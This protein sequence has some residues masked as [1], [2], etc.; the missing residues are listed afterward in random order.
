M[1]PLTQTTI[2]LTGVGGTAPY[3]AVVVS[4]PDPPYN[5]TFI[6]AGGTVTQ[7]GPLQFTLNAAGVS[8]GTYTVHFQLIDTASNID[9][10]IINVVVVD[11][12]IFNILNTSQNYEPAAFPL[13]VSMPLLSSGG[14]TPIT[15][16][17]IQSAT[18]MPGVTQAS[19][20]GTGGSTLNFSIPV[21]GSWTIG[22]KATDALNNSV[23]KVLVI[24]V[25]ATQAVKLVDGQVEVMVDP[26]DL[27]TGTH[28]FTLTASD[29]NSTTVNQQFSYQ[30]QPTVSSIRIEE[31]FFDHYWDYNDT[32]SI[33]FPVVG[34]F[35]G[36]TLAPQQPVVLPNGLTVSVDNVNQIVEVAGPP[37]N[38]PALSS[39]FR[40]SQFRIP[41]VLQQGSVNVGQVSR[42]YTFV[43]H[44]DQAV[45]GD[46]GIVNTYTRPYVVG[47]F[48]GL[49]P[50]KPYFNSPNIAKNTAYSVIVAPGSSLPPGLS[51][52]SNTGLIYGTLVGTGVPQST[53][54]Y[55]DST[56]TVHGTVTINWTTVSNDYLL[57]DNI[58]NIT[59]APQIG[60]PINGTNALVSSATVPLAPPTLL[61]GSLPQ[62]L[63][64]QVDI[65]GLGIDIVGTPTEAGYFDLWFNVPDT[66]G[67]HS[68]LYHRL[69]VDYVSPLSI[70]TT[71]IPTL[72]TGVPYSFLLQGTGG[73]QPYTWSSPQWPG[74][75]NPT[76]PGLT[77]SSS[78]LISGTTTAPDTTTENDTFILTDVRGASTQAVLTV[79]VND[80]LT[81]TTQ[82]IPTIVP[83]Q[84]YT[85]AM[86]AIGGTPPYTWTT[87]PTFPIAGLSGIAFD[88]STGVFSGVTS[89]T[90]FTTPLQV[91]VHDSGVHTAT[92][93]Y[94]LQTGSATGMLIV[95]SGVGPIDRGASY[96][97][98]LSLSGP[99]TTPVSW[100]VTSD[101]PNP[102][103]A[104]LV[105]Q[106]TATNN[107]QTATIS[108][109]YTGQIPPSNPLAVKVIAV[110]KNGNSAQAILLLTTTSSLKVT[111]T[112]LP[113]AI[114]GA[115]TS[116]QLTATSNGQPA[117]V[118]PFV[119]S[120]VVAGDF[121]PALPAGDL[122]TIS[123]SSSGLLLA[124][125]PP[126]AYTGQ[127]TVH[128]ADAL[129]PADTASATLQFQIQSSSLTITTATLPNATSGRPYSLTLAA[130]GG[131]T[132]Y[133]WSISPSSANNLPTGLALNP[134]TGAITGTTSLT[135]FNK[136]I[137]FRV[138][139]N[140]G[141]HVDK[142]LN[143]Q[144]IAGLTLQ[145]G[146]DYVDSTNYGYIGFVAQG[147][148]S[149]ITPRPNDSFFVVATG[150]VSTN[151]S[152]ITLSVGTSG[153]TA[154]IPS[155]GLDTGTGTCLIE[156]NG[157][158]S[159]GVI[160]DNT[161][162]LSV[163]DSGVNV[164]G[165]FK[166]RVYS[167]TAIRLAATNPI[168]TQLIPGQ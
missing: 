18:T 120:N 134:S 30:V 51:L 132:P 114:I 107:G 80:T 108:G 67:H 68:Y 47:D 98:T 1:P 166:W 109:V 165:S 104:G 56:G 39:T 151:P 21:V 64:L 38:P 57:I 154:S 49:N 130:T 22:V 52:D 3:H 32:T 8:P 103:P 31:A 25:P 158:F 26:N 145:A 94:T 48:V 88:G 75:L 111:T 115:S 35:N 44:D 20:T 95:T 161:L 157:S 90:G 61:Y 129:S 58:N 156:L 7:N 69:F 63:T 101:S 79:A 17:I 81:I 97:G 147:S 139:D 168:P 74:G 12:G 131:T 127:L 99:Y 29:S 124:A 128:V 23:S 118:Q 45:P 163:T 110:D 159:S 50:Q 153:I 91:T 70:V 83:G 76:F 167:D 27:Q 116:T 105:L 138:T 62:G 100:Q 66:N 89:V 155:G 36:L 4:P 40:N 86:T 102:L 71:Q 54:Q 146:P 37:G 78:G 87:V 119:W 34:N 24:Q 149:S 84:S 10:S 53:I 144:V 117:L 5:T 65:S 14:V 13:A 160:G 19:L 92:Q 28:T 43:C 164:T 60:A 125:N 85:F 150:V 133:T 46:L 2:T 55:I 73:I 42:E 15:W 137:I 112:T 59:P 140:I 141:A 121:N 33:I 113:P 142:S 152:Q 162:S 77:L 93:T 106:A 126:A 11:P 82:A 6:P 96:L 143:L 72:I 41:L 148:V 9:D 135:G 136:P 122:A 16:T 123:I